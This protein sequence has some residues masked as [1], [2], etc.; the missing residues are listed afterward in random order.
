MATFPFQSLTS[1]AFGK[2]KGTIFDSTRASDL[3]EDMVKI[4]RLV[5]E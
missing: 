1:S 2:W 3:D 5:V 4:G